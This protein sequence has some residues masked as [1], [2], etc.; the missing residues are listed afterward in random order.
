MKALS[1][2]LTSLLLLLLIPLAAIARVDLSEFTGLVEQNH[3][4]VVNISTITR[5][6]T[7][8]HPGMPDLDDPALRDSPLGDFLRRFLEQNPGHG[9]GGSPFESE[10]SGSGFIISD[11]GFVLTNNHV[12]D[13]ATEVTVR[14]TD[15]RQFQARVVGTDPRS[16]VAL[17]KIDATELPAVRTGSSEDLNVGEWVL[18]IGSPFGFDFSVTAGIV[19]AKQRALPNESYVPFIQTDVA[20][21]P[22]NSG[23]P[24]FNLEG[25]VVGINAQIYSRS[26]GFMGLSF[27]IPIEIAMDVAQQLRDN[28][29]VARAWLGVVIQE[30]TRDLADSFGLN[31]AEGALVSRI[32]PGSP[33]EN[34]PLEV[35]DIIVGFNGKAIN[36]SSDLPPVVGR[37]PLD[38]PAKVELIREGERRIVDVTLG[39]LPDETA[40]MSG[41]GSSQEEPEPPKPFEAL[42]MQLESVSPAQFPE[43][44]VMVMSVTEGTPAAEA[45]VQAGDVITSFNGKVVSDVDAFGT[46]LDNADSGRKVPVLVQRGD[47]PVFLA[48]RVPDE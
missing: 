35:G 17:L 4:S 47:G 12:V 38:T 7:Q 48:L 26:G 10:S 14:L 46:A 9:Q 11:D 20:I 43:G 18:A 36:L 41:F 29:H 33:A 15:R 40:L 42:G 21:N 16:D 2:R 25:E 28:G 13:G 44:G 30:V 32:L 3:P 19:S 27:A 6:D 45:E 23:G 22:G 5:G 1:L 24:L 39:E 34:S 8:E 31:R 37:S